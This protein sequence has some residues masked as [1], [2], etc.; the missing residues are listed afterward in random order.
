MRGGS[1]VAGRRLDES[2]QVFREGLARYTNDGEIRYMI[3]LIY[4]SNRMKLDV[5]RR[6]LEEALQSHPS[7]EIAA[8]IRRLLMKFP[9]AR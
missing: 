6:Y 3:G 4:M 2:E 7:E 9:Q 8:E 5:A 1:L